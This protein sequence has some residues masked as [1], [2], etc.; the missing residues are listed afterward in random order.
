MVRNEVIAFHQGIVTNELAIAF[1]GKP[2][3]DDMPPLT[4]IPVEFAA[5]VYRLGHTLVPNTIVVNEWGERLNPTDPSLREPAN[6]VPYS[7]L[8]GP[9]AQPA[10]RFDAVLSQTMHTLLI[11]FSPTNAGPGDLIGGNAPNIGMGHSINGV[12]HLD[13]AETNILRGREQ[14]LP[15]GEE[16]LAML[17]KRPYRPQSDGNTDLFLYMLQ[18]AAPL[19]HLG[20]VGSDVFDRT[21]GGV[22]AADP[23]RYTNP[24]LFQPLQIFQFHQATVEMLLLLH[25]AFGP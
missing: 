3:P 15:S 22:L 14:L 13:L 9:R 12:M 16:Y 18:E 23:C 6:A 8:F 24:A 11:P 19:G 17:N 2:V 1:T 25:G 4:S 20:R 10:S 5:A 21:I 7:L